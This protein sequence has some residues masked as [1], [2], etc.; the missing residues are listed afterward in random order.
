MRRGLQ[1]GV[2]DPREGRVAAAT[3]ARASLLLAEPP[4]SREAPLRAP[5]PLA[6]RRLGSARLRAL[7]GEA[8]T[9]Q[10][11]PSALTALLRPRPPAMGPTRNS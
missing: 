8:Q 11:R 4:S 10:Q 6:P 1:V 5:P 2:W 9:W 7:R 3:A